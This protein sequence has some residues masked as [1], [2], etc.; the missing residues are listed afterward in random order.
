MNDREKVLGAL[1]RGYVTERNSGKIL[2][3]D[4]CEDMA[5]EIMKVIEEIDNAERC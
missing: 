2:D 5:T 4:L 1:A 3:P